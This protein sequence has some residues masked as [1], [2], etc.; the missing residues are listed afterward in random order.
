MLLLF[1]P[2]EE[3]PEQVSVGE[4]CTIPEETEKQRQE[5]STDISITVKEEEQQPLNSKN[6]QQQILPLMSSH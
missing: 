4:D 6:T 1:F 3:T 5:S 2:V